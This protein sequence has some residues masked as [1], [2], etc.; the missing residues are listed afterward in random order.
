[1]GKHT[2]H[3]EM[4][5]RRYEKQNSQEGR[6]PRTPI[7]MGIVGF[8]GILFFVGPLLDT[9]TVFLAPISMNLKSILAIY[10]SGFAVNISQG[11][12]TFTV[13]FLLGRPMLEKI[14]R[15]KIKYGI[16]EY[17]SEKVGE[18]L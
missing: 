12:S 3:P 5:W 13:L 2:C 16:I 18:N 4:S 10:L 11:I 17:K 1:M 14:E 8:L 9:C 6:L 7:F 15:I